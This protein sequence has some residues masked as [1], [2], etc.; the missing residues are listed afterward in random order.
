MRYLKSDG[1]GGVEESLIGHSNA[2]DY[3]PQTTPLSPRNVRFAHHDRQ[4]RV[5]AWQAPPSAE[6][7]L[8]AGVRGEAVPVADPWISGYEVSRRP[9]RS[10]GTS[11]QFTGDWQ[12]V[13]AGN[14]GDLSTTF[15]DA[16]PIEPGQGYLYRVL[17][18]NELGASLDL[19]TADPLWTVP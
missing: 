12:V 19:D 6:L 10:V 15:T 8:A 16:T 11:L 9:L 5:I 4:M 2:V 13:R 7:T 14:D 18:T 17:T 1:V 3:G